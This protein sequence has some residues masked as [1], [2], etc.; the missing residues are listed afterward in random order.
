MSMVYPRNRL[1]KVIFTVDII[2][3]GYAVMLNYCCVIAFVLFVD[4]FLCAERS[5]G[6][7]IYCF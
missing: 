6:N 2:T 1:F 7:C 4:V 5:I 3:I